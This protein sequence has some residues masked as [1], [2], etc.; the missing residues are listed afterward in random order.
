MNINKIPNKTS[1]SKFKQLC[2]SNLERFLK[3][4]KKDISKEI[5]KSK[6][7]KVSLLVADQRPLLLRSQLTLPRRASQRRFLEGGLCPS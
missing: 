4:K 5:C 6:S 2:Q 1:Y 3:N 7:C